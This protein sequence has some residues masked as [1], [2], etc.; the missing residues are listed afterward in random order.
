M[1]DK[2][3]MTL[4]QNVFL[5][6]R[7]IVDNVYSNARIEGV[8]VTFPETQAILEGANVAKLKIDEIQCIL[9]LRDAWKFVIFSVEEKFDLDYICK[10]N[11]YVARNESLDWGKLRTRQSRNFRCRIYTRDSK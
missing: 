4:E 2:Y 5:A 7:N 8:N 11:E 1:D 6:K 3:N 10:V 9:N